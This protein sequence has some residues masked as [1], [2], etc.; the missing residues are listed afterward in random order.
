MHQV[1]GRW[2]LGLVLALTTA[3][4]WATLPVVLKVALE[5]VDPWTLTWFRFSVAAVVTVTWLGWRRQLRGFGALSRAHWVLLAVAA[6]M[7]TCNYVLYV[8][9]LDYTTPATTQ[10]L[11]QVGP[12]LLAVGGV[13]VFRERFTRGQWVGLSLLV[14]GLVMFFSD[15]LTL[16]TDSRYVTGIG[17]VAL[18]GATW[19]TYA[20]MQ[21]QLLMRLP[22]MAIMG[23]IYAVAAVL[24]FP[25]AAPRSLGT[26]D[27]YHAVVLVFCA[28][29]TLVAYSAF[30]EGLAHW[31]ASRVGAVLALTPLLTLLLMEVAASLAP[32]LVAPEQ[33]AAFGWFG[34]A[35]AVV[36]SMSVSLLA[37]RPSTR[38]VTADE[39]TFARDSAE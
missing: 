16:R 35:V 18:A 2:R 1:S 9:G 4:F 8:V 33:I 15:Q 37:R 5:V 24:L 11:I 25:L 30:A 34:A 7:L 17:L 22:S 28:L 20:L 29:N 23:F 3:I 13:L 12:L 26:L 10:L 39:V 19:A 14:A 36:G 27:A 38:P 32:G 6:V 31:D 21:K